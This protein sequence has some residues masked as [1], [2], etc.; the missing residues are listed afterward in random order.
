MK[1]LV[2]TP[3]FADA[4]SWY[5]SWGCYSE[6]GKVSDI[7]TAIVDAHFQFN[8]FS[9][10][11]F[12]AIVFH[13]PDTAFQTEAISLCKRLGL[14]IIVDYD[15]DLMNVDPTNP[16]YISNESKKTGYKEHV[17]DALIAADLVTTTTEHLRQRF[18][19]FNK[20]VVVLPNAFDA[21]TWKLAD[22]RAT[23]PIVLWR[24]RHSHGADLEEFRPQILRLIDENP[25]LFFVFWGMEVFPLWLTNHPARNLWFKPLMQ[26]VDYYAEL[27]NLQAS[28]TI[29]P[30]KDTQFNRGKSDIAKLETVAAGSLCVYPDWDEWCW[31]KAVD[32]GYDS[33]ESFYRQTKNLLDII[34]NKPDL[35]NC[36]W[37]DD[38]NY[39]KTCR[40]L[41][42]I[43]KLRAEAIINLCR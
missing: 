7:R 12:D 10:K 8:I 27:L 29:V 20:N 37:H 31:N 6:I 22:K 4:T 39:I 30:L 9:V 40:T 41:E 35:A 11:G 25:D 15:D 17:R 42:A 43:N 38:M 24:G 13:R 26:H 1:I 14:K 28:L 32:K 34:K 5:R 3:S 23:K 18:L 21:Y 33:K 19:K 36:I 16:Y 2:H